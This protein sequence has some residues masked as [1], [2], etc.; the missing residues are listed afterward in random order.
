[1]NRIKLTWAYAKTR[2]KQ[3]W[4]DLKDGVLLGQAA[5]RRELIWAALIV[6]FLGEC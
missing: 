4:R 2:A 6:Y 3:I 1:M 5:S